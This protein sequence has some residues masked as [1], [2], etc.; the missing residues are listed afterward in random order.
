MWHISE[1][2]TRTKLFLRQVLLSDLLERVVSVD[3]TKNREFSDSETNN[4]LQI[5]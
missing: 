3:L 5:T 4:Q 1:R 2:I